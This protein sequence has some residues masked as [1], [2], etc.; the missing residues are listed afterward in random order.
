M[1]TQNYDQLIEKACGHVNIAHSSKEPGVARDLSV[2]PY[3]PRRKA[4]RWLL[5]M[6]G[7]VSAPDEI[8][9][10]K[11]DYAKYESSRGR[12]LSGLVQASLITK[13]LVFIGY[14]LTDPNY[15]RIVDEVRL[16]LHPYSQDS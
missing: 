10:T 5:K 6:H 9:I 15:L 7:C 3:Q 4:T 12:A 13:H 16:A 1:V 11:E 8:V 2:I 14:S